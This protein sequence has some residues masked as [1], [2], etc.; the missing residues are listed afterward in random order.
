MGL[1]RWHVAADNTVTAPQGRTWAGAPSH[2]AAIGLAHSL[3]GIDAML[4]HINQPHPA[5]V[6]PG[7]TLPP[8][9]HLSFIITVKG[10]S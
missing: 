8:R 10:R 7:R 4:A 1:T 6:T 2:R 9:R 3:A 5:I